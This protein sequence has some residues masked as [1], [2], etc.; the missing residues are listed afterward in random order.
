MARSL[1]KL[2]QQYNSIAK[3]NAFKKGGPRPGGGGPRGRGMAT[4]KPK[5]AK[6]NSPKR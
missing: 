1:E 2:Q 3:A 6:K 5:S 4:G